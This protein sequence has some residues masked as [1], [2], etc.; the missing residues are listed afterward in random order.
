ML[1]ALPTILSFQMLLQAIQIDIA[2]VPR[3][4]A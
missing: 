2:S 4:S 3:R 1:V